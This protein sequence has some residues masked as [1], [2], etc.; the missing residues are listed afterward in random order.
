MEWTYIIG[1]CGAIGCLA[2]LYHWWQL[3]RL[4]RNVREYEFLHLDSADLPA[5]A[6]LHFQTHT[7]ALAELGFQ[8]IGDFRMKPRPVEVYDRVFLSDNGQT[9]ATICAVLGKG[10][11]SQISILADGTCIH[12]LSLADPHPERDFEPNDRLVVAYLPDAS[13]EELHAQHLRLVREL[14]TCSGCRVLRFQ[15][16]QYREILVYDQRV[17]NRWRYRHGGLN[18]EPPAPDFA[19]LCQAPAEVSAIEETQPR[20]DTSYEL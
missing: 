17:F 6:R 10:G 4:L 15:P 1:V 19:S 18:Q 5:A 20:L 3:Q 9:L 11:V 8:P 12:S 16:D 2:V 7:P 13:V 14:S